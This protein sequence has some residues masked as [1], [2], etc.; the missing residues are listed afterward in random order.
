MNRPLPYIA[1]FLAVFFGTLWFKFSSLPDD[2]S[3][4]A[5]EITE[6]QPATAEAESRQ[7]TPAAESGIDRTDSHAQAI[8][9]ARRAIPGENP[10][11]SNTHSPAAVGANL[12]SSPDVAVATSILTQG[13]FTI[14]GRVADR[15][16]SS[17][18]GIEV[19]ATAVYLIEDGQRKTIP[20][21]TRPLR[22]NTGYDG[23]FQFENLLNGEYQLSTDATE[24][25]SG[26][27]I[28]VRAGATGAD[29]VITGRSSAHVQ[30]TVTTD[31]GEFLSGVKVRANVEGAK[32]VI[33]DE[34]G[35]YAFE[36]GV[37]ESLTAVSVS[38]SRPGFKDTIVQLQTLRTSDSRSH[39]LNIVLPSESNTEL[40][41]VTGTVRGSYGEP[42]SGQSVR[43]ST[44]RV[45]QDYRTVTDSD[46]KFALYGV[47]PA[48]DYVL[49]INATDDY[50]DHIQSGINVPK[51]NLTLDVELKKSET[52]TLR[53]R[54]VDANGNAV[55]E[56]VLFLQTKPTSFYSH[57][58]NGDQ[59]G[60]FE[61]E[62]APAGEL[63]FKTK[64][65]PYF[66]IE[67]IQLEAN[68]VEDVSLVLDWGTYE[69]LGRVVD[70]DGSPVATSN[71]RLTWMQQADGIHSS[72]RRSTT[73]DEQ[74]YFRFSQ[75]GPGV[76]DL[77]VNASGYH[78][79]RVSHDVARQGSDVV[80]KLVK[81]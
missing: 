14:S 5:P 63:V 72:S 18:A 6:S 79:F 56:I 36:I 54:M 64:S 3:I 69:L 15:D 58:V 24:M 48:G 77:T 37:P 62:R 33:T 66:T 27:T 47:E 50:Q 78:L 38:A 40:A 76:H 12:G 74:G 44:G 46:G 45:Q 65:D 10:V 55:P 11:P 7:P 52:G 75:L 51:T 60:N 28:R 29:L 59:M 8:D 20:R 43:L 19:S 17:L 80:V 71:I 49:S 67:G 68:L 4:V 35:H 81:R 41:E 53:G 23:K 9:Q 21:G 25:L 31:A 32:E 70:A 30:G 26:A 39:E 34:Y 16:G 57:L 61:I 2:T 73:A 22:A 13:R 1:A 42:I